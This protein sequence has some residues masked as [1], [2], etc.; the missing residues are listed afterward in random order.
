[1][2]RTAEGAKR[3]LDR[4]F[5]LAAMKY[6]LSIGADTLIPPGNFHHFSFAVEHIDECLEN[7]LTEE[8]LEYL[9]SRLPEATEHY[10]F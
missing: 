2:E 6:T 10:F 7:P 9:K 8:D 1:M 4:S 3:E 5:Q